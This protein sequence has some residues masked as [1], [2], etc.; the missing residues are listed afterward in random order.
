MTRTV[1]GRRGS[2]IA[3]HFSSPEHLR[4]QGVSFTRV[5]RRRILTR[6]T[7]TPPNLEKVKC[8]VEGVRQ[9]MR[10]HVKGHVGRCARG[11]VRG[12]VLGHIRGRY[13]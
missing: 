5:P 9:C 7:Q 13:I 3:A 6:A 2:Q 4:A 1:H 12:R 10:Q 11:S 8:G